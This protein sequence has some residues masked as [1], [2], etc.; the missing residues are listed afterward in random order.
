MPPLAPDDVERL[1]QRFQKLI[2][3]VA[4]LQP[5]SAPGQAPDLPVALQRFRSGVRTRLRL[6]RELFHCFL[7]VRRLLA[8]RENGEGIAAVALGGTTAEA[9]SAALRARVEGVE[10]GIRSQLR[11]LSTSVAEVSR[12]GL[13]ACRLRL[14]E[15]L[16]PLVAMAKKQRS[17][18]EAFSR[19]LMQV[20]DELAS[21]KADVERQDSSFAVLTDLET[22]LSRLQKP[23]EGRVKSI[24]KLAGPL[25]PVMACSEE[26]EHYVQSPEQDNLMSEGEPSH[27]LWAQLSLLRSL[28]K[29]VL[30]EKST[31]AVQLLREEVL[32]GL[33]RQQLEEAA[34]PAAQAIRTL[35]RGLPGVQLGSQKPSLPVLALVLSTLEQGD[36]A[37]Q[38]R[39]LANLRTCWRRLAHERLD[40]VNKFMKDHSAS[41]TAVVTATVTGLGLVRAHTYF[42]SFGIDVFHY[43]KIEDFLNFGIENSFIPVLL[44]V[45]L[46]VFYR[47]NQSIV[48]RVGP[49][50]RGANG[51]R[52]TLTDW[53]AWIAWQLSPARIAVLALALS[54]LTVAGLG[55]RDAIRVYEEGRPSVLAF[56]DRSLEEPEPPLS[57][58]G[59]TSGRLFF[60]RPGEELGASYFAVDRSQVLCHSQGGE[61]DSQ[62]GEE[63][64]CATLTAKKSPEPKD[65]LGE[66]LTVAINAALGP[67]R[68]AR[69]MS[70]EEYALRVLGCERDSRVEPI[71][72]YFPSRSSETCG[73][74]PCTDA[75]AVAYPEADLA[76]WLWERLLNADPHQRIWVLGFASSK[77]SPSKNQDLAE[78]RAEAVVEELHRVL[79]DAKLGFRG[80][81][82]GLFVNRAPIAFGSDGRVDHERLDDPEAR[83][84]EVLVC[85]GSGGEAQVTA[86]QGE[87]LPQVAAGPPAAPRPLET[88]PTAA[89]GAPRATAELLD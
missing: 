15:T 9:E 16:E 68:G 29:R 74:K 62:G 70:L 39:L 30:P 50:P 33:P 80:L 63:D 43:S 44:F 19:D 60:F 75:R 25:A 8:P 53:L 2:R 18:L 10:V 13:E 55:W 7:E 51:R 52:E 83:S 59:S 12:S 42:T 57:F 77:G 46:F 11:A 34:Q 81:G 56:A 72:L 22:R 67:Q 49:S 14:S 79:P 28:E 17:P 48:R 89:E 36:R 32:E 31:P 5:P 21:L 27:T 84:V 58:V 73:P 6:A 54:F 69:S 88:Q 78:Q 26:L 71:R 40:Q 41:L 66:L 23:L 82:E 85:Q 3:E 87:A 65:D 24:G 1:E 45:V 38:A 4:A 20:D 37:S 86:M 76:E 61:E 47:M 64:S 35:L